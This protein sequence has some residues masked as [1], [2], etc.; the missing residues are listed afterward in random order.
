MQ[1]QD[2]EYLIEVVAGI[3]EVI[4]STRKLNVMTGADNFIQ[5]YFGDQRDRPGL[6]FTIPRRNGIK[7]IIVSLDVG[8]DL[9]HVE[10]FNTQGISKGS[11]A[12]IYADRLRTTIEEKTGLALRL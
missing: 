10:F 2:K 11:Y 9:Y 1:T 7:T 5:G 6:K 4:G 8:L 12:Q 3:C